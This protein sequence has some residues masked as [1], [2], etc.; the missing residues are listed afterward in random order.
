MTKVNI[1]TITP[2]PFTDELYGDF[3]LTN[4]DDLLLMQ[5]IRIKGIVE[6]LIISNNNIIIS[7]VRRYKVARF[8]GIT[9]VPVIFEDI[10]EVREI[11][12]IIHNQIQVHLQTFYKQFLMKIL[13][14]F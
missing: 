8:L 7:G 11:D 1:N 12:V 5:T 4:E 14:C 6:P 9:E 13:F 2:N 10:N 3:S